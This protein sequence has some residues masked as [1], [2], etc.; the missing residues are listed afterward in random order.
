MMNFICF[1]TSGIV[2][3]HSCIHS[4][5]PSMRAAS[6]SSAGMVLM[7]VMSTIMNRPIAA[8]ARDRDDAAERVFDDPA[9]RR[10]QAV[11]PDHPQNAVEQAVERVVHERPDVGDDH[12][13]QHVRDVKDEAVHADFALFQAQPRERHGEEHRQKDDDDLLAGV[14]MRSLRMALRNSLSVRMSR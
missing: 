2:M 14:M 7:A 6:Y 12:N 1:Q 3:Y 9:V 13:G 10:D 8:P 11:Q 5:A 4:P